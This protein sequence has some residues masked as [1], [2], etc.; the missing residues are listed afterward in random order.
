MSEELEQVQSTPE[1]QQDYEYEVTYKTQDEINM[2]KIK[3]LGDI[4]C[5]CIMDEDKTT[6][7]SHDGGISKN[8]FDEEELYRIKVKILEIISRL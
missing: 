7:L 1:N 6:T 4:A 8:L 3:L 2:D 5:Y